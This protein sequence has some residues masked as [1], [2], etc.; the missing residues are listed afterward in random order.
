MI[1]KF[2]FGLVAATLAMALVVPANA[3]KVYGNYGQY[4]HRE[5]T[6][7]RSSSCDDVDVAVGTGIGGIVGGIIGHQFGK[8]SG[9]T[10][11]TIGGVILGGIAGNAIARDGC[12]DKRHDAYYYNN[13]Y[14]D[15]FNDPDEDDQYEWNNP[16]T[17]NHGYVTTGD[18]YEDGYQNNEG[19]C[20]EFTQK[21]YIDGRPETA[22][23]VACRQD[24]GT[25]RIVSGE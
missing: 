10:A 11:A 24:D 18:T 4:D 1:S 17:N 16:Y 7:P 15:A 12:R 9:N 19:P 21:V 2:G 25:W 22:T 23:G 5:D 8:G 3:G 6:R 13:A 20:R 14:Y